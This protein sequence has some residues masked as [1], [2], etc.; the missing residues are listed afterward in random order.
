MVTYNISRV[1]G[2]LDQANSYINCQFYFPGSPSYYSIW[3]WFQSKN[4]ESQNPI[5]YKQLK[6]QIE[7]D[8][9]YERNH[10]EKLC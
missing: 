2:L 6:E 4:L 9:K 1:W 5:L 8:S 3:K 7:F 10:F